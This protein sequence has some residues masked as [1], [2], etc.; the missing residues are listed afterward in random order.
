MVLVLGLLPNRDR[1][2]YREQCAC[3][4][5]TGAAPFFAASTIHNM[6]PLL[7]I[8]NHRGFGRRSTEASD[9]ANASAAVI[10]PLVNMFPLHL[11]YSAPFVHSMVTPLLSVVVLTGGPTAAVSKLARSRRRKPIAPAALSEHRPKCRMECCHICFL[12]TCLVLVHN[13]NISE[14]LSAAEPP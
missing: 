4:M 3:K 11:W 10:E 6:R 8:S 7:Q 9:M 1:E 13:N 14:K 2:S 5:L 12:P